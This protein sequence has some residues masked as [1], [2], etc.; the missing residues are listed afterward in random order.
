MGSTVLYGGGLDQMQWVGGEPS[1]SA[2]L[3]IYTTDDD[4]LS[5]IIPGRPEYSDEVLSATCLGRAK[6]WLRRCA[7][8]HPTCPALI[9]RQLPTRVVDVGSE[10]NAP[11]LLLSE[12][13]YGQWVALSHCWGK[14]LALKT[15]L[16]NLEKHCKELPLY[17]LP[18]TFQD[19]IVITRSLGIPFLWIDALCI[20]QDSTEDLTVESGKMGYVYEN[21]AL[22]IAAEASE[23]STIGISKSTNRTRQVLQPM[24]R[25]RSH[26]HGVEGSLYFRKAFGN[27]LDRGPLSRRAWTIQEEV[28]SPRLLRFAERQLLWR[29][30]NEHWREELPSDQVNI[31]FYTPCLEFRNGFIKSNRGRTPKMNPYY[32]KTPLKF[33]LVAIG[34]IAKE[35][36]QSMAESNSYYA[37]LWLHDIYRALVWFPYEAGAVRQ[38]NYIAPSWSWASISFKGNIRRS[39]ASFAAAYPDNLDGRSTPLAVIVKVSVS[40]VNRDP[41][42]QVK[43]GAFV[44]IHAPCQSVCSCRVPAA[45]LDER[46]ASV[47]PSSHADGDKF[48]DKFPFPVKAVESALTAKDRN[49]SIQ[50]QLASSRVGVHQCLLNSGMMHQRLLYLQ[51]IMWNAGN[52]DSK[53]NIIMALI[54]NPITQGQTR[55]YQRIGRAIVVEHL[56]K[57]VIWPM[58]TV[59]II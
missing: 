54:L 57:P 13:R 2:V 55:E 37:G 45:F 58:E 49:K 30:L 19:A 12:G 41:F 44:E 46:K 5:D 1:S 15:E 8:D 42:G 25:C 51:I 56:K 40:N 28:L 59:I 22:T 10:E 3:G 43:E 47:D 24:A 38:T 20:I 36:Q 53:L 18:A 35:L 52:F 21:A 6:G 9:D 39:A 16:K 33:W 29:C 27:S 31:D 11:R 48:S 7:S 32:K 34:G 26:I 14:T 50:K 23:N 4:D 17:D